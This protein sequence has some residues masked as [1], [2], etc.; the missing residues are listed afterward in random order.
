MLGC[1]GKVWPS[2]RYPRAWTGASILLEVSNFIPDDFHYVSIFTRNKTNYRNI[3]PIYYRVYSELYNVSAVLS[4][5]PTYPLADLEDV[6]SIETC[7]SSS[8][9]E[10]LKDKVSFVSAMETDGNCSIADRAQVVQEFGALGL[11]AD[12]TVKTKFNS[13][14]FSSEIFV[15]ALYAESS[16]DKLLKLKES[17]PEGSFQVYSPEEMEREIDGSLL[18]IF[19]MA[20]FTVAMGSLWS[21]YTKHML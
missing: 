18:L 17:H 7:E 10:I 21:G 16:R 6:T 13:S 14:E 11:I 3:P 4:D 20:T 1:V 12:T 9:L 15:A 2:P 8:E 5:A 19:C